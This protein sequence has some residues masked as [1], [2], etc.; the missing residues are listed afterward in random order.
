MDNYHSFTL[1]DLL[2]DSDER[3]GLSPAILFGI[4]RTVLQPI[5]QGLAHNFSDYIRVNFN[6]D[7]ENIDLNREKASLDIVKLY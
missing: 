7:L 4:D 2:D 6:K 1:S 5:L 3:V